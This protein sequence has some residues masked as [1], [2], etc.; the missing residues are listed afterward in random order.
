MIGPKP[1]ELRLIVPWFGDWQQRRANGF[2]TPEQPEKFKSLV[3]SL[4]EKLVDWAAIRSAAPLLVQD[5]ARIQKMKEID[6]AF[7][8]IYFDPQSQT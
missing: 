2:W 7:N 1:T 8:G 3:N 4:K 6:K 5:W